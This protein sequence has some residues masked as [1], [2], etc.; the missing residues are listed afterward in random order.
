MKISDNL[1]T[2]IYQ[3]AEEVC[4]QLP[5]DTPS[6]DILKTSLEYLDVYSVDF[7]AYSDEKPNNE[8]GRLCREYGTDNVIKELLKTHT[9]EALLE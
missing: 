4:F 5:H 3:I 1:H 7:K 2:L 6:I 9:Y 8:Y